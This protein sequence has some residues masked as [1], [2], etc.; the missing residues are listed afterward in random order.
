MADIL[1]LSPLSQVFR[2]VCGKGTH[3]RYC[4]S[5]GNCAINITPC[6]NLHASTC[7]SSQVFS[8]A[9]GTCTDDNIT[10]QYMPSAALGEKYELV[11]E[12]HVF[13]SKPGCHIFQFD[14]VKNCTDVKEG[15][16]LGFTYYGRGFAEITS[17]N[18]GKSQKMNATAF[19]FDELQPGLGS[20]ITTASSSPSESQIQYA[21]AAIQ[22]LPSLFWF[23]HN[24]SIGRYEEEA[25]VRGPHNTLKDTTTIVATEGVAN[26]TWTTPKFVATNATYTITI[27]PHKGYNV[28]Y[29][30][31]FGAG[32]SNTMQKT[33]LDNDLPSSY[34][35]NS[36]GSYNISLYAINMISFQIK[37]CYV[38]VQDIVL[39][40]SFYEPIR[41]VPLG[42][43][44]KVTWMLRQGNGV[45]ISIDFGDGDFFHNGSFDITY[46][47]AA[48]NS[49]KYAAIGEYTVSINVSNCVSNASIEEIAIVELPLNGVTCNVIHANRDIEVNETVTVEI[50]VQQGTNP[51]FYI[52]FG[53][54]SVTTTRELSV[55]HLYSYYAF[56]NVSV[57]AYNNVSRE[58]ASQ[59]IQV[60][61]PVKPLIG[62]NVTCLHTN[63][64]DNTPCMLNITEGTDFKCTWNWA[65]GKSS[66]TH[67]V[68]LGNF[69]YHNYSAVGHYNVALNCT[70][71]LYNTTAEAT[72]IVE[73]PILGFN[74]DDPVAKPFQ[75]DFT[76]TWSTVSGT[77]AIF[78]VTFTHVIDGVT[79]NVTDVTTSKGTTSGSAVITSDMMPLLGIYELMVTAINYVTPR[80]TIYQSVM[81]DIPISTPVLTRAS[82]FVEVHIATNFS[83]SLKTGS[84]VSLWWNFT[85]GSPVIQQN[86][87]GPFPVDGITIEHTF[88]DEGEYI[89]QL[90]G[91]NSVSNFTSVI[92]VFIQNPP[93][94]TL[95][96]NSPQAI[97]PGTI[98]FTISVVPGEEPPTDANYTVY[99]GDGT[100]SADQPFSAPL[101]LQHSY[102]NHGA[103]VMNITIVNQVQFAFLETEV[104]VQTPIAG[105]KTFLAHT[106]PKEEEGNPGKGPGNTYFPNDFPV[107]FSTFIRN[108][109]N[110][111]YFWDFDDGESV[112]TMNIS[113][114][115]TFKHPGTYEVKLIAENAI[116]RN[117]TIRVVNMQRMIR[118]NKFQTDGSQT[119]GKPILFEVLLDE[120][121]TDSCFFVNIS[122]Y[123]LMNFKNSKSCPS[124]CGG[125]SSEVKVLSNNP[126]QFSWT[127]RCSKVGP[128]NV[129]VT[130]CN[131]VN[132]IVKRGEGVCTQKKCNFPNVTMKSNLVGLS[133]E[134]A[135]GYPKKK[136]FKISNVIALDCEATDKTEFQWQV[137]N[138][139]TVSKERSVSLA[140]SISLTAPSLDVPARGISE[141][142]IFRLIF[143]VAM[144]NVTGVVS[145]SYGYI[146]IEA[147]DIEAVIDQ[148]T[149]RAVGQG[150]DT[151]VSSLESTDPDEVNSNPSDFQFCWF[152]AKKGSY[153]PD[154]LENC[155]Q[156][157][158]YPIIPIPITDSGNDTNSTSTE[159]DE[160]GCFGYPLGRLNTSEPKITFN[161]LRMTA[162]SDYDVCVQVSKDTRKSTACITLQITAG[163][164]PEVAIT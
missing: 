162:F 103:Y 109:T 88:H 80:Q 69:T 151:T 38:T 23:T 21:I 26:V 112:T 105:L 54:G 44:T 131:L 95:T 108:G 66:E 125:A 27:H 90:F 57:S 135:V 63:F 164:P 85:D 2:P 51:E 16:I 8:T 107:M 79:F 39:G 97:P 96:T 14:D 68:D 148:G 11:I 118:I 156:L 163:D 152:C 133:P 150:K 76:V 53:D 106:G 128:F 71:R 29:V 61:K 91:N 132:T 81:I 123:K 65:D 98:T 130:A 92:P 72:A 24:Y 52:D 141:Y 32:K 83:L 99:Y 15:D 124:A 101:V 93:N 160:D 64:T 82:K 154:L 137:N 58:N 46:L 74:V 6:G 161:T 159:L 60:H 111:S 49:H 19:S 104:E 102:Q 55:Q 146:K 41:P 117:I 42:N 144:V 100:M 143:S 126:T 75:A 22:Q 113:L 153:N 47:F 20:I 59:E 120:A 140:T 147:S 34:V 40:L 45:N 134:N 30:V 50:T 142:G 31:D 89:I 67:F 17:R 110:V 48:M 145:Y 139:E 115:H 94:L 86:Y 73:I 122:G 114:N 138:M 13:L 36:S 3:D 129:T 149:S 157:D 119:L 33:R 7:T 136:G 10:P 70:N 35:Y 78:N 43:D 77:D 62:F 116:S 87:L 5:N 121:G 4:Y 18:S 56:F 9:T 155:T 127:H 28:T 37:A 1:F 158:A 12:S 84:N 25:T